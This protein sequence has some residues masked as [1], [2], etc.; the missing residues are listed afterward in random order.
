MYK[1]ISNAMTEYIIQKK[2]GKREYFE[3]YAYGFENLVS[4]VVNTIFLLILA[5]IVGLEKEIII[6]MIFFAGLRNCSGG[7]HKDTHLSCI[8]T[9]ASMAFMHIGIM[10]YL[11]QWNHYAAFILLSV[12]MLISIWLVFRYAPKDSKNKRLSEEE[13]IIQKRYSRRVI[14]IE[15]G[16]VM[17]LLLCQHEW[18]AVVAAAAIITQSLSLIPILND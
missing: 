15:V 8:M 5:T 3:I 4:V 14:L 17:G 2:V 13:K 7:M 10:K 12:Y 1:K 11:Y 16:I 9:Y 18:F 6:Y